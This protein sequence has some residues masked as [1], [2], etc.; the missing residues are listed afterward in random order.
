MS[1]YKNVTSKPWEYQGPTLGTGPETAFESPSERIALTLF[2]VVVSVIFSLL[3]VTYY[4]RMDLGDWV[5]MND[6]TLLW[7]NT[8]V[9]IVSSVFLQFSRNTAQGEDHSKARNLFIVGGIFAAAFVIGQFA[10]WQQLSANGSGISASAASSF[11]FLLTGMHVVHIIGGLWVWTRTTFRI[12]N[13][14]QWPAVKLSIELCT[15]YWHFLLVLWVFIF[16]ALTNT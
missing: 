3:A 10:V 8:G 7:V 11:F 9:L 15:T 6:P 12:F 5:P 14:T 4:L 1:F 2:L 16:A 13:G